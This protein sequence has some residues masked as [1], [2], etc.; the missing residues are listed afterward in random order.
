MFSQF[1]PKAT[2]SRFSGA[3]SFALEKVGFYKK[4][5]PGSS[6]L[7]WLLVFMGQKPK[8]KAKPNTP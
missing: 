8:L 7:V 3:F 2:K 1:Y 6:P 4:M 5:L